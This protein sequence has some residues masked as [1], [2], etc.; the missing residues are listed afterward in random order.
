VD[1]PIAGLLRDLKAR[2]MLDDTLVMCGSEFGRTP[3]FE[4]QNGAEGRLRNG[5]DHN[6]HGFCMWLAGA[7]VK[8]GTVIGATDAFGEAP[9]DNPIRP[10]DLAFSILQLLGVDPGR[11]YIAPRGRPL[12][13][14]DSGEFIHGLT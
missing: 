9:V 12:K 14:L 10:E 2:G 11:Q 4:Y 7:G 5:R 3:M 1:L 13:I 6:P 8:G